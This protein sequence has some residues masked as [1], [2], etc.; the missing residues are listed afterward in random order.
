MLAILFSQVREGSGS[1][2]Q[3]EAALKAIEQANADFGAA[4][5]KGDPKAVAEMYTE[6]ARLLPPNAQVV[7]GKKAIEAYWKGT[8]AAGIKTIELKTV[9]VD[10]FGDTII[11]QGTATLYGNNKGVIDKGKYLVM[12]KRIDGKWKLHRDCWNSSEPLS[13]K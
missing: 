11:E 7:E 9:E 3:K 13:K 10:S 2:P 4:Y 8:M 5:A 12:W 6:K 1:D